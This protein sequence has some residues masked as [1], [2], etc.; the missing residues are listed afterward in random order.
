MSAAKPDKFTADVL[1]DNFA[2]S[3]KNYLRALPGQN[4]VPLLNV[5]RSNDAPDA[6][7]HPDFPDDYVAMAALNG[8]SIDT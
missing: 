2:P 6:T 5:V 8:P 3:F 1:W 7:P 4:G